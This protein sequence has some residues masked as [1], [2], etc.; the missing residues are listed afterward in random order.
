MKTNFMSRPVNHSN[1]FRIRAHFLICYTALL[2]ERLLEC[3]LEDQ[4]SH[5]TTGAL[6]TTLKNMNVAN[7]HDVEYMALYKGSKALDALTRLTA[8]DL[9]RM[10]YKPKE[11][12][13]KIRKILK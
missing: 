5:V 4:G 10:H 3:K 11:L 7:V 2:A 9:D 1:P 13:K 6:I 12:N 8:L